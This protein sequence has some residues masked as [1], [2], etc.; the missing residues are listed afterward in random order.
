MRDL[1][2]LFFF[3]LAGC[4]R[5]RLA[6][7]KVNTDQVQT[8]NLAHPSG[9][10]PRK[11]TLMTFYNLH[12]HIGFSP[13]PKNSFILKTKMKCAKKHVF[14]WLVTGAAHH[15]SASE[16]ASYDALKLYS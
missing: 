10:A 4:I 15:L 2:L 12:D 3:F 8:V 6:R 11:N 16:H 14:T 7:M 1:G 13:K 5:P 9:Q